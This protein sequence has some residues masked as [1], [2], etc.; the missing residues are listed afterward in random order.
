MT[1]INPSTSEPTQPVDPNTISLSGYAIDQ[2]YGP[3]DVPATDPSDAKK[4]Q[5][6][7]MS[8][9]RPSLGSG[10]FTRAASICS[11]VR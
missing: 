3:A 10:V 1:T 6:R 8:F 11:S 5:A 4:T 2:A 9:G 7:P